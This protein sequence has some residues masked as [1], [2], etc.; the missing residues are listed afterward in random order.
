MDMSNIRVGLGGIPTDIDVRRLHEKFGIPKPGD[1]I[2]YEQI[3]DCIGNSHKENRFWSVTNAW[4]KKLFR[5]HNLV[6]EAI[7]N[8]G[9]EFLDAHKRVSHSVSGFKGGLRKV[10]RAGIIA[11]STERMNLSPEEQRTCDYLQNT[12]AQLKLA[13][14][15]AARQL[16]YTDPVKEK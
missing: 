2:S 5:E 6:S 3:S 15:T 16:T 10:A 9:F 4:R 12:A 14:A 1:V 8:K 13:A 11:A 7:P